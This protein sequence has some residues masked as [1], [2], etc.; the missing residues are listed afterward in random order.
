MALGDAATGV[1]RCFE[2]RALGDVHRGNRHPKRVRAASASPTALLALDGSTALMTATVSASLA[3]ARMIEAVA[4]RLS[5]FS[6]P[7]RVGTMMSSEQAMAARAGPS[8]LLGAS[9]STSVT[10][11]VRAASTKSRT[12]SCTAENT[13]GSLPPRSVDQRRTV[14]CGSISRMAT[15][16]PFSSATTARCMANSDFPTPPFCATNDQVRILPRAPPIAI[17]CRD[18]RAN[19]TCLHLRVNKGV[20]SVKG[21]VEEGHGI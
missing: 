10:P 19:F 14:V 21:T 3:E 6:S 16:S 9:M 5:R 15:I 4:S 17:T 13:I 8:S 1:E 18:V 12:F 11:K 20:G 7:G 2:R